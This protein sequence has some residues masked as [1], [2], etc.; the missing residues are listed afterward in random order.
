MSEAWSKHGATLSPSLTFRRDAEVGILTINR[1]A[2]RNAITIDY[3]PGETVPVQA[4][5]RA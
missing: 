2:K 4:F 5:S 3:A 1:P